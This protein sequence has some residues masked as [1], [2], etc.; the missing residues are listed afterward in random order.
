MDFTA[1]E[2]AVRAAAEAR[3]ITE[4]ELYF[5]TAEE[6]SVSA[7][8]HEVNNFTSSVEGGVCLRCQAGGRM[9]YASTQALD[10]AE[11]EDLVRRAADNASSLETSEPE[12]LGEAGHAYLTLPAPAP[13]P[14]AAQLTEAV[15]TAQNDLYAADAAVVDG[16]ASQAG[17]VRMCVEI[18]NSHGL[19][20][21][22]EAA[23]SL[24]FAEA[25]VSDGQEMTDAFEVKTGDYAAIDRAAVVRKLVADAKAKMG[26]DVAPTGSYPVV[27]APSAFASLLETYSDIFS[28]EIADKGLSLLA[29]KEGETIAAQGVTLVDDPFF[30][31][32]PMQMPF[33]AEGTPTYSKKVIEN[34]VLNTLLYN[35]KTAAK[36]GRKTTANAAKGSY[37]SRIAVEPFTLYLQPGA[38]AE[39]ELLAQAGNGVYIN[40]LGGLHAGAN[41]ISGDF[42]LQSA[43]FLIKDGKKAGAVKAFTVAGN[44]YSLLR[45]ITA[46]ASNLELPYAAGSTAFASPSVLVE[47]LSI[48]G[49]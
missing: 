39:E 24:F 20:L 49:K 27:F 48:A 28:S 16:S 21:R 7:F 26:A 34:G 10:P 14:T 6:T 17:A 1:F 11:A 43:G 42:S 13:L 45:N 23:Y 2:Q 15:L 44:F 25:V 47:G 38:M 40:S 9:G 4:Y 12:P 29:G 8:Q 19:A 37:A 5:L 3:G 41:T 46:V 36:A 35:A 30:P 31:Q 32:N 33:D 18:R 22:H